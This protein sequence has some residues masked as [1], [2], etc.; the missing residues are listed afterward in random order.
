MNVQY[1]QG[2]VGERCGMEVN[3]IYHGLIQSHVYCPMYGLTTDRY[4][5]DQI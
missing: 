5:C 1:Q 2:G 3:R 4:V